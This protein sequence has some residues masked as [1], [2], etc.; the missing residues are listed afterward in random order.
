MDAFRA[1]RFNGAG[2]D[3]SWVFSTL[4]EETD[5]YYY[6]TDLPGYLAIQDKIDSDWQD[7]R[8]WDRKCLLNIARMGKFSS[9][10]TINEYAREIWG[11]LPVV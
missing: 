5:P 4:V 2:E 9:D 8:A 6:L 7:E 1:G 3:T 11:I 10:R